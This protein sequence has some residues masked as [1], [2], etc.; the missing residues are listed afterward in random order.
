MVMMLLMIMRMLLLIMMLLLLL[1]MLMMIMM[2][3]MKGYRV[4]KVALEYPRVWHLCRGEDK[5]FSDVGRIS[6]MLVYI[7][8]LF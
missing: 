8:P 3:M 6:H 7:L 4:S 2:M 5:M 1:M